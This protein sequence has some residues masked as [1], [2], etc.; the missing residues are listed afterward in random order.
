VKRSLSCGVRAAHDEHVPIPM[1]DCFVRRDAVVHTGTETLLD[2]GRVQP[3]VVEASCDDD[4]SG[5][6]HSSTRQLECEEP[7]RAR[8]T[9]C[10]FDTD[11]DLRTE[12]QR[13]LVG[14]ASQ[15]DPLIPAG[16]LRQF[17]MRKLVH[18]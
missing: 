7:G 11:Q 14:R 9:P 1:E 12:A 16:K 13:L 6:D 3:H 18:A 8:L 15:L 5:L 2:I 17:S 10:E 4:A